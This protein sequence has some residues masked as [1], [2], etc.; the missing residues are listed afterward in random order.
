MR[1]WFGIP[2]RCLCRQ[3]LL[4]EHVEQHMAASHLLKGRRL[5]RLQE[6]GW[7]DPGRIREQHDACVAEMLNRGYRHQ[8]PLAW[9]DPAPLNNQDAA[10]HF[11]ELTERC[12]EC[13][14]RLDNRK[15]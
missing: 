13:R 6:Q 12:P 15:A 8:S 14:Q 4:G 2:K 5:G 1:Q 9:E 11:R 3:H 10:R 7:I